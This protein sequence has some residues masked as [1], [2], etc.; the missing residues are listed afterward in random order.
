MDD[1]DDW[2][3]EEQ[4]Y[5]NLEVQKESNPFTDC[6]MYENEFPEIDELVMVR[7]TRVTDVGAY[8]ML[9]EYNNK[10]GII[11]LSNLSRKRIRSVNRHI[12]VGR[13]EVLQVLRVDSEKGYIDLSK[14]LIQKD[15][16][17]D[18]QERYKKSKTVH[19]IL[20]RVAQNNEFPLLELYEKVG[21]PLSQKYGH[22]QDAFQAMVQDES[23]CPEDLPDAVRADLL[24]IVK[25]RLSVHPVKIQAD[26]EVQCFTYEGIEAIKP[27]LR[28]GLK[29]G[30]EQ[31]Y[32]VKI[33]LFSTPVYLVF[34][35]T[36][37]TAHGIK[38]LEGMIEEIRTAIEKSGG[39]LK[40][41]SEPRVIHQA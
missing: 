9:L 20:S 36:P 18:C 4:M 6:R 11:L 2:E 33:Q 10:E 26:I 3:K 37:D 39:T 23:I 24:K 25:H 14:K 38:T 8:V 12:R 22:A 32:D 1:L 5:D 19:S 29:K 21:W 31:D 15:D 35:V 7:V 40:V 34:I 30:E 13:I 27:A 17:I 41:K 28:A 16:I